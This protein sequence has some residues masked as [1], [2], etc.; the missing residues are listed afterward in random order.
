[1]LNCLIHD[2][3]TIAVS[4]VNNMISGCWFLMWYVLF[5]SDH[6]W[7]TEAPC[8]PQGEITTAQKS[9]SGPVPGSFFGVSEMVSG[10][11][12]PQN[13][14]PKWTPFLGFFFWKAC[15]GTAKWDPVLTPQFPTAA[16]HAHGE[17]GGDM[18]KVER[19]AL[20]CFRFV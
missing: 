4:S 14:R 1:M 19:A 17:R 9:I 3:L 6:R 20:F 16:P 10:P 12:R 8:G 18:Q 2:Y 11:L 7:Q 13:G 15:I 5:R